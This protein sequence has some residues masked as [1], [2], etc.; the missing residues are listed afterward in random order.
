MSNADVYAPCHCGSGK[1]YKFCCLK[2]DRAGGVTEPK[3]NRLAAS[4]L[5]QLTQPNVQLDARYPIDSSLVRTARQVIVENS[6]TKPA[7]EDLLAFI[8]PMLLHAGADRMGLR[9]AV[10]MGNYFW[11]LSSLSNESLREH[12]MTPKI[13][14]PLGFESDEDRAAFRIIANK[15]RERHH[16]LFP[17][18]HQNATESSS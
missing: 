15:M 3:R 10:L 12:M 16:L 13:I 17:H 5:D 6:I 8:E 14:G 4:L 7:P 1:K 18:I 11:N 9:L 2:K